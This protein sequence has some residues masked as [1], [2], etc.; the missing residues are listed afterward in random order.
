MVEGK[1]VQP[2]E[3]KSEV[4]DTEENLKIALMMY[5]NM[6]VTKMPLI[7]FMTQ[8]DESL[9]EDIKVACNRAHCPFAH[10]TNDEEAV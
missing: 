9:A 2:Y 5:V 8:H 3:R 1:H 7:M 6:N 4:R 10:I